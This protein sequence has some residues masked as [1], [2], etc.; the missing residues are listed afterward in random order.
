MITLLQLKYFQVLAA[1]EHLTKTAEQLHVSQ[2]SLSGMISRLEEDLNV[3]LFDRQGRN[4]RLN[5]FGRAY[6]EHVNMVFNELTNGKIAIENL[7]TNTHQRLSLA[8]TSSIL[9]GNMVSDFKRL[10]PQYVIAQRDIQLFYFR[11]ELLSLELDVAIAGLDDFPSQGLDHTVF[12]EEGIFLCVTP[13][14]PLVGKK[15]IYLSELKD[16]PFISLSKDHPFRRYCDKICLMAGFVPNS[17]LECDYAI[18]P[19]L[20]QEDLGVALTTETSARTGFLGPN[21]YIP[22]ADTFARRQMALYWV[23]GR[24]FSHAMTDFHNFLVERFRKP[25]EA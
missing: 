4:I 14:S 13:S 6:L 20:M 10:Y 25:T 21:V 11:E 23:N 15:K 19:R 24:R 9:W 16:E 22:V 8:M 18:R 12:R 17:V 3:E 5:Q 1:Q 2:A 7:K